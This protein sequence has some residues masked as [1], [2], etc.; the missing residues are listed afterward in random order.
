LVA[1]HG[2]TE[3]AESID[4]TVHAEYTRRIG[5]LVDGL[6]AAL[7]RTDLIMSIRN[8]DYFTVRGM[9]QIADSLDIAAGKLP[10]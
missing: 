8:G 6:E 1:Y 7:G 2:R 3:S 10:P 4:T 9:A 5:P